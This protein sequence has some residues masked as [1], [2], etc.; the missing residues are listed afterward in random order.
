LRVGIVGCGVATEV[1][2][3][4]RL[5]ALDEFQVEI[6][7][8]RVPSRAETLARRFGVEQTTSDW[9]DAVRWDRVDVV[10]VCTRDHDEV[11]IGAISA[12]RHVFVEKPI[13]L[14]PQG[15]TRIV[16]AAE[17][18]KRVLV[19]GYMKAF[20]PAFQA[21]ERYIR[22]LPGLRLIRAHDFKGG[23]ASVRGDPSVDTDTSDVRTLLGP[24]W[25]DL[26]DA[27]LGVLMLGSHDLAMLR[28][29]LGH[30]EEV[31]VSQRLPHGGVLA[32]IRYGRGYR[33]VLELDRHTQYQWFDEVL[34]A[35]GENASVELRPA[36]PYRLDEGS[37][38]TVQRC[39]AGSGLFTGHTVEYHA[40]PFV[41]QWIH[42]YDCVVHGCQPVNDGFGAAKDVEL[43]EAIVRALPEVRAS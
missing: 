29:L 32:I 16:E 28:R 35:Y 26:E 9:R 34:T 17:R 43:A 20:D 27:Y 3:L 30:A 37:R 33:A 41:A 38:L 10:A 11:A 15:A 2:H 24:T 21:A 18:N 25:H 5:L 6:L 13:S 7:C 36:N 8:D 4:P 42:F 40:D 1:L 19:V 14:T 22:A 39:H 31:E 23:A 12:G